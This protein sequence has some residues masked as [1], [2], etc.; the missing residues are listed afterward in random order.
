M[1]IKTRP[2]SHN[3]VDN[4]DMPLNT[5]LTNFILMIVCHCIEC[6]ASRISVLSQ[7]Y[8]FSQA[9]LYVGSTTIEQNTIAL[10]TIK[11]VTERNDHDN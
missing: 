8:T 1:V 11:R 2:F 6:V 5:V 4:F 9:L 7:V 3:S 10:P